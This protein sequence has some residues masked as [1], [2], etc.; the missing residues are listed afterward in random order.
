VKE[1][2]G[3]GLVTDTQTQAP[4]TPPTRHEP[5]SLTYERSDSA[6]EVYKDLSLGMESEKEGDEY[7][8]DEG[9]DDEELEHECGYLY[10]SGT[11]IDE[12]NIST[13]LAKSHLKSGKPKPTFTKAEEPE[14]TEPKEAAIESKLSGKRKAKKSEADKLPK[15]KYIAIYNG[16]IP[17]DK[18]RLY[19][20]S[21][22]GNR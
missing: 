10:S 3:L 21:M 19:N 22:D 18:S 2:I 13:L 15:G 11:D 6:L 14:K 17:T 8:M 16:L 4:K 7:E 9:D 5:I 1:D 12:I 20:Q